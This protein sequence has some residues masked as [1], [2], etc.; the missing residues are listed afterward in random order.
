MGAP[1]SSSLGPHLL[2]NPR[3]LRRA[4][5]HH[6]KRTPEVSLRNSVPSLAGNSSASGLI[7]TFTDL[8]GWWRKSQGFPRPRKD[9]WEPQPAYPH[10]SHTTSAAPTRANHTWLQV[11]GPRR[12]VLSPKEVLKFSFEFP[13]ANDFTS[14]I[15]GPSLNHSPNSFQNSPH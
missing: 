8:R 14:I 4:Q 6:P 10:L 11:P 15:K 12:L 3:C 2:P 5:P 9:F 1:P 13:G 7:G